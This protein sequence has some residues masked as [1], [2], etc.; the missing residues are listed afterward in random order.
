MRQR[1]NGAHKQTNWRTTMSNQ[2]QDAKESLRIKKSIAQR[3]FYKAIADKQEEW[4]NEESKLEKQISFLQ[5]QLAEVKAIFSDTRSY[6][7]LTNEYDALAEKL[8]SYDERTK[9]GRRRFSYQDGKENAA[10]KEELAFI[11]KIF[12][13]K[14][15]ELPKSSGNSL[16]CAFERVELENPELVSQLEKEK[17]SA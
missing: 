12:E 11:T 9:W 17:Q 3:A 14:G 5:N 13:A 4:A 15:W 16:E 8:L 10:Q 7:E 1:S 6:K 2:F